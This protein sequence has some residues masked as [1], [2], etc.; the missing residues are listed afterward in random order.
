MIKNIIFDIGN[1]LVYYKLK[2]QFQII[3]DILKLT[4]KSE[5]EKYHNLLFNQK[6]ENE[7]CAN[8][9]YDS[10]IHSTLTTNKL[11]KTEE[12][13]IKKMF[14]NFAQTLKLIPEN[15]KLFKQLCLNPK[16]KV[17][18]LSDFTGEMYDSFENKN[19]FTKKANGKIISG[20][21]G[22]NKPAKKIYELLLWKYNLKPKEC[23]FIDDKIQNIKGGEKLGIKGIHYDYEKHKLDELLKQ[24]NINLSL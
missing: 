9:S 14:A 5:I 3:K 19:K 8:Y 12:Q 20:Y 16:Y 7:N 1:V 21:V 24:F 4:K 2:D 15:I 22:I 10:V 6:L 23:I 17:Y 11:T 18:V 13:N